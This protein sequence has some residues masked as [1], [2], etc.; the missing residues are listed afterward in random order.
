MT[1]NAYIDNNIMHRIW[2]RCAEFKDHVDEKYW[3]DSSLHL[4]F[5]DIM[6]HT[7]FICFGVDQEISYACIL[8]EIRGTKIDNFVE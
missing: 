1:R 8:R 2:S 4:S 3:A 7:H 6:Y 5:F